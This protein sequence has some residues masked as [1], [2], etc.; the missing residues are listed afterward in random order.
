M[1]G[2]E[3]VSR[4]VYVRWLE[5][6]VC[7]IALCYCHTS[8]RLAFVLYDPAY[9]KD[10]PRL[11]NSDLCGLCNWGSLN[12]GSVYR[13]YLLTP[14]PARIPFAFHVEPLNSAAT[15][16]KPW[17]EPQLRLRID[18]RHEASEAL[19]G[20]HPLTRPLKSKIRLL[21]AK[22]KLH[23]SPHPNRRRNEVD[24]QQQRNPLAET[25]PH[26]S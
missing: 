8:R 9:Q 12:V 14:T 13:V 26:P 7:T 15:I 23:R 19:K 2:F 3:K 6:H 21:K 22:G 18:Q 16:H 4:D 1:H 17:L 11:P 20:P 24:Q 25:F 5:F 10:S